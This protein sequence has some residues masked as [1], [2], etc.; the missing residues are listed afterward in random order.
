[1]NALEKVLSM[2]PWP[3][4]MRASAHVAERI[5]ANPGGESGDRCAAGRRTGWDGVG[6]VVAVVRWH[7][8]CQRKE[9]EDDKY[10][11]DKSS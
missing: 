8:H 10:V 7:G 1:M 5:R 3:A 2:K 6:C 11:Q 9:M 4:K